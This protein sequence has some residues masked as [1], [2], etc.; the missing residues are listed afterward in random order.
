[1]QLAKRTLYGGEPAEVSIEFESAA[2][3][4]DRSP[5]DRHLGPDH[6]GTAIRRGTDDHPATT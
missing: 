4:R 5:G 6:P 1:M 3:G 2:A